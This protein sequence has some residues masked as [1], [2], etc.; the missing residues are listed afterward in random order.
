M[1]VPET[2]HRPQTSSEQ[3]I[4]HSLVY[5]PFPSLQLQMQLPETNCFGEYCL[6]RFVPLHFGL[7]ESELANVTAVNHTVQGCPSYN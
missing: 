1:R 5:N 4:K 7:L 2:L 3:K 6:H